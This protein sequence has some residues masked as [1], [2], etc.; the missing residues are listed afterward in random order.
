MWTILVAYL[1][2]NFSERNFVP[3]LTAELLAEKRSGPAKRQPL[4]AGLELIVGPARPGFQ[5]FSGETE[6][7]IKIKVK[8]NKNRRRCLMALGTL[9]AYGITGSSKLALAQDSRGSLEDSYSSEQGVTL[10]LRRFDIP[11]GLLET[12]IAAYEKA[13]G[14]RVE[15]GKEGIRTLNSPGVSGLLTIDQALQTLLTG[16][17][18]TARFTAAHTVE[19]HLSGSA[20]TV[21]VSATTDQVASPKYT[22]PLKDTPQTISIVTQRTLDEQNVTTLRDALRNVAG[23]SLAAGEGGAQGDNLTVRGFSARNDLFIDGMRDFG[24]YYR[25][26][27]DTE[28]VAVLQGPSSV[29]F[30]RG[31]TGGVVDQET[32]APTLNRTISGGLNFGSDLTRRVTL[33]INQPINATSAFRLNV[34][35]DENNIAG[36]N[37]AENRRFGVAPSLAFGIGTATRWNFNYMHQTADDVPDYG[38]PWLFNG[39]APVNRN[40]F[41]GFKSDYLRTYDDIVTARVEHD[42]TPHITIRNQARFANYVRDVRITE[43]Q[44][45]TP[46]LATPLSALMVNRHEIAV[47]STESYLDD[48]LDMTARFKT[49]GISHTLIAGI[50]GGRETSNPTRPTITGDPTTSLLNPN[51]NDAYSGNSPITSQVKTTSLSAA[52]YV[53]DTINLGRHWDLTGG[54][55]WDRF[56]TDYKQSIAPATAF[57]R[58]DAMPTWRGA[59]V[60]KPIDS[61]S[62]YFDYGTSF[63]PSAESLS[64]SAANANLP[65]EKNRT[66]ELGTKWDL[67]RRRLSVTSA[68]FQTEK[69]NAREPD[70]TNPLLN[71]LA[72]NQRVK[73]VQAGVTGHLT[74]KWELLSSYAYLDSRV[75]SSQYYPNAVGAQLANVP[76]HTFNIWTEYRLPWRWEVGGGGNYVSSRT[77]SSTVP[78]D[79]ITGLVKQVPGYWVFNGMLKHP[80]NEHVDF[81]VNVNNIANRYYYDEL[82]PAH[83]VLG[84]GRSAQVGFKFKF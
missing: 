60:Y 24:S 35:G 46:T 38:V 80:I 84:P 34:M 16:T 75:E 40:N 20:S 5:R 45:L 32:K 58:V 55:R 65:P 10:P 59:I 76:N 4:A 8:P 79:P 61:G 51:N 47:N 77:A 2:W 26:P 70:P 1:L 69:T 62:I 21:D 9:A 22:Q 17:G 68:I 49:A 28:S 48:Q 63:N 37:V 15:F 27:F 13:A 19:L 66:V 7:R 73:G 82:H 30:G 3:N 64:L 83:I 41:Y 42:L 36:R 11:A 18:V 74:S 25:D 12:A 57:S 14:V 29:T 71:V 33:D 39:A 44:I 81:Q 72:G 23:I 56:S 54:V 67:S 31:S 78:L 50:E 43:P 53:L 6:V 52:A